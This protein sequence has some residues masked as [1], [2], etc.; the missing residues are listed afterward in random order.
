[1]CYGK[2]DFWEPRILQHTV[3][4]YAGKY[5]VRRQKLLRISKDYS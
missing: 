2:R 3:F 4:G 5:D 1:M